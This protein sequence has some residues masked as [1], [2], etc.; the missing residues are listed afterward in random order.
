MEFV[1]EVSHLREDWHARNQHLTAAP[2]AEH[3]KRRIIPG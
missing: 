2:R 3:V 1:N